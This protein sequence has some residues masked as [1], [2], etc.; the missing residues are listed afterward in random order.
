MIMFCVTFFKG[1][2]K[3]HHI[4]CEHNINQRDYNGPTQTKPDSPGNFQSTFP[5]PNLVK[6]KQM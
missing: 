4:Y 2:K 5:I 3:N 6:T 1:R